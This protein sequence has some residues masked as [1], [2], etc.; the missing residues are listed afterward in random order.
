MRGMTRQTKSVIAFLAASL[1]ITAILIVFARFGGIVGLVAA[2][3][4]GGVAYRLIETGL[5]HWN[6]PPDPGREAGG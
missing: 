3:V 5:A 2:L 6:G 4:L 1:C